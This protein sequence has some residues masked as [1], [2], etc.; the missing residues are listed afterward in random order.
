M[1]FVHKKAQLRQLS[2]SINIQLK[3]GA[4]T[5]VT[6]AQARSDQWV[7][8]VVA[9]DNAFRILQP[10][11]GSPAYWEHQKKNVLAMVRQFGICSFFVTLS[12]AETKWKD[13]LKILLK[14]VDGVDA[15]DE[16]IENLSFEKK[17]ELIRKDPVTCARYFDHRF[18]EVKRTWFTP[19]DR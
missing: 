15:D 10:I 4:Q 12:A 3:K 13:L 6:A 16:A 19:E 18:K 2:N 11:T 7:S 8:E 1:L 14:A 5:G 9:K 17:A